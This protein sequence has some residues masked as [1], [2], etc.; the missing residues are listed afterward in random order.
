MQKCRHD[1]SVRDAL[2]TLNAAI[3]QKQDEAFR[4]QEVH[5]HKLLQKMLRTFKR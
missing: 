1:P 3:R 4:Q 2:K 5:H